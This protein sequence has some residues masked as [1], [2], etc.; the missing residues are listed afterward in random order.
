MSGAILCLNI[1][2]FYPKVYL[3]TQISTRQ[4]VTKNFALKKWNEK[5]IV[6]LKTEMKRIVLITRNCLKQ[7]ISEETIEYEYKQPTIPCQITTLFT[8]NETLQSY[9]III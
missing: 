1:Y 9:K 7:S 4:F 6:T 2:F 3:Y 8:L 5:T